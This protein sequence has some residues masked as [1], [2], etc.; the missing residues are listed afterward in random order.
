MTVNTNEVDA[1]GLADQSTGAVPSNLRNFE[2]LF[3]DLLEQDRGENGTFSAPVKSKTATAMVGIFTTV[4]PT[5]GPNAR[6]V[7][8]RDILRRT[9]MQ[10]PRVCPVDNETA[11][12]AIRVAFVAG[13]LDFEEEWKR[14]NV[15]APEHPLD[16]AHLRSEPDVLLMNV[17]ENMNSG[18]TFYWLQQASRRFP[19]A[20]YV[21]KLDDDA[22]LHATTVLDVLPTKAQAKGCEAYIGKP[23]TCLGVHCPPRYCGPPADKDFMKYVPGVPYCWSYMQGGFYVLSRQLAMDLTV[24]DHYFYHHKEGAEDLL[25]GQAVAHYAREK[26]LCVHTLGGEDV[27]HDKLFFHARSKNEHPGGVSGAWNEF[28]DIR[29]GGQRCTSIAP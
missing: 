25:T 17:R 24:P 15:V 5:D 23:W 1:A 7:R 8:I 9:W 19:W 29:C 14:E 11:D 16:M 6:N 21:G 22:F 13:M 3:M 20:D 18:K 2:S 10:H 26:S 4:H 12:C 27:A 28:Y